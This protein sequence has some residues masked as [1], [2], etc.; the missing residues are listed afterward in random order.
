LSLKRYDEKI[1]Y[2]MGSGDAIPESLRQ[3]DYQVTLLTDN[4]LESENLSQYDVIITGIRAY[5]TRD[6]LESLKQRLMKFVAD[7]GTLIDQY[8]T[9]W[10]LKIEH[11]G[12]YPFK[13][14]RDRVSVEEAPVEILDN[15]H[16]LLNYPNKI[17]QV[18]FDGWIQ[19]RGLYFANEWDSRY[20]TVLSSHDPGETAKV[21]GL[22]Y[23][24][25]GKGHYIYTGYSWFRELPAGVPGAF[26]IF[27]NMISVGSHDES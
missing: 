19:E 1:G 12:P 23:S 8:N 9:T 24:T 15:T 17:T 5:N 6:K 11:L 21:G 2:I 4:D 14:S 22:L 18:D 16:S 27:V 7:G 26:R 3:L 25:Y 13:I 20:E 10:G